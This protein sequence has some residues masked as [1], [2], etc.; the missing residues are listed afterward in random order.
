MSRVK[1]PRL[2]ALYK[3]EYL[4]DKCIVLNCEIHKPHCAEEKSL[5]KDDIVQDIDSLNETPHV[6][7]IKAIFN[8]SIWLKQTGILDDR[9]ALRQ[10]ALLKKFTCSVQVVC[11][12]HS[13]HKV[14]TSYELTVVNNYLI[15]FVLHE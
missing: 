9:V 8:I 13:V 15:Y 2:L 3:V 7:N 14:F 4:P 5:E 11:A 10:Y 1:A 6:Q 12:Q